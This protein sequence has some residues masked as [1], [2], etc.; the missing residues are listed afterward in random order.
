M[1]LF[2]LTIWPSPSPT[3]TR[4]QQQR[5]KKKKK[6]HKTIKQIKTFCEKKSE[7][8]TVDYGDKKGKGT[9]T[10]VPPGNITGYSR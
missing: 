9:T 3:Q 8:K 6:P 10:R 4:W 7:K 2:I 1:A 5:K